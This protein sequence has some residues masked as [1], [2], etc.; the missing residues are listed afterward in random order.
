MLKRYSY[1]MLVLFALSFQQLFGQRIE[2]RLYPVELKTKIGY[3]DATG[4]VIIEPR[5]DGGWKFSEGFACVV[6]DGKTGFINE[7][8]EYRARV[9]E[10]S[11]LFRF[12]RRQTRTRRQSSRR[13]IGQPARRDG[14]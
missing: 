9:G 2:R 10:R 5:F 6:I 8:G 13:R 3:I 1:F 11:F 12:W 4:K 7:S 14:F